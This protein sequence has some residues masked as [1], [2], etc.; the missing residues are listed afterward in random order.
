MS[1]D[2][3]Y[4]ARLWSPQEAQ[5]VMIPYMEY[6]DVLIANEEDIVKVLGIGVKGLNLKTG[7]LNRDEY[8]EAVRMIHEKFGFEAIGITLRES[9]SA[10]FN[11]WS[12]LLYEDGNALFSRV[13]DVHII[14]RVG[15]G[16]CFAAGL[17]YS[18][19]KGFPMREKLEFAVAAS[20]LKHTMPGDFSILSEDEVLKL[21]GG[22]VSGRVER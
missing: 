21:V 9:I 18:H 4:R 2:L 11:R 20:A 5:K 14:D 13:Y 1:C 6:V 16:D 15:A 8:L 3:N 22:A 17:I 10:N 12:A 19:I 7:E